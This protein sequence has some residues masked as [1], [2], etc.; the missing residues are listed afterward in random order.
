MSTGFQEYADVA[1][2]GSR[3]PLRLLSEPSTLKAIVVAVVVAGPAIVWLLVSGSGFF[4]VDDRPPLLGSSREPGSSDRGHSCAGRR[5]RRLCDA[6]HQYR[7]SHWRACGRDRRSRAH[8]L[9]VVDRAARASA[10]RGHAA[11]S[12]RPLR[13][14][15][16]ARTP[17]SGWT[18]RSDAW[19]V[20]SPRHSSAVAAKATRPTPSTESSD[21]LTPL[22]SHATVRLLGDSDRILGRPRQDAA[23]LT[24]RGG[25]AAVQTGALGLTGFRIE[26]PPGAQVCLESLDVEVLGPKE[27]RGPN[28]AMLTSAGRLGRSKSKVTRVP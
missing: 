20:L 13:D 22:H 21:Y 28:S 19:C 17:G 24:G 12:A 4:K 2:R 9:P 11:I 7:P 18:R 27:P 3:A 25:V 14:W 6:D 23:A 15:D 5:R 10:T 1:R 16:G 26:L 8:C